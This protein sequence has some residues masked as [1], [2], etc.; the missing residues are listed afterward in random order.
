MYCAEQGFIEQPMVEFEK[1]KSGMKT[2]I[3][4]KSYGK[5]V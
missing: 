5:G 1:A 3:K 2:A 4:K